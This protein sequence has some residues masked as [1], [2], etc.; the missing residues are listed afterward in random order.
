MGLMVEKTPV[1]SVLIKRDLAAEAARL[2]EEAAQLREE[3]AR[4][5]QEVTQL[6]HALGHRPLTEHVVGMIMLIA[7]CD[8]QAAW[9]MLSKASQDSNRKVR[10]LAALIGSQVA[11]GRGL[12]PDLWTVLSPRVRALRQLTGDLQAPPPPPPPPS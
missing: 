7:S 6:Q 11:A 2:R 4:L 12:P 5:E 3:A 1:E 10:D 9:A 8:E